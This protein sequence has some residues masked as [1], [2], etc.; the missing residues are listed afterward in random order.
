MEWCKVIKCVCL[1]VEYN[2]YLLLVQARN[3]EKYYFPGGKIDA[4]ESY[5]EALKREVQEELQIDL[6]ESSNSRW[7][8]VSS[9]KHTNRTELLSYYDEYKLGCD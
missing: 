6:P 8:S 1:V 9:E 7:R 4:N 5:K 3:R 2:E